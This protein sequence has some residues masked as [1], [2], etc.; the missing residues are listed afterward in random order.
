MARRAL[1]TIVGP[2]P[3]PGRPPSLRDR[4][5]VQYGLAV[6]FVIGAILATFVLS[7]STGRLISFPF[8]AAVVAGAW[9]GLGPGILAFVLSSLAAADFWTPARFDLNIT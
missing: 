7:D 4:A 2:Q 5:G 1:S 3:W 8:Y 6:L 9:L